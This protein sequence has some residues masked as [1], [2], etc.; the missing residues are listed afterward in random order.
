MLL[1]GQP[2]SLRE[3]AAIADGS[4]RVQIAPAAMAQMEASREVVRR[5][6]EDHTAVYGINTGFGKLCEMRIPDEELAQLQLNLVRSHCCG[7]GALL[8]ET[9]VRAMMVLRANALAKGFSGVRTIV[10]E[11]E[12]S[13]GLGGKNRRG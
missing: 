1:S 11:T 2:L 9:E 7:V 6:V 12:S 8:S 13:V 5:A 4:V 3:I 10:V